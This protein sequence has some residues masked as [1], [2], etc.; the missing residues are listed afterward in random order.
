MLL[1][2][3][4][5]Y[6]EFFSS[7]KTPK[8]QI[9]SELQDQG[10]YGARVPMQGGQMPRGNE[11]NTWSYNAM[12][13]NALYHPGMWA[14]LFNLTQ[15]VVLQWVWF[16]CTSAFRLLLQADS[17][18]SLTIWEC[19]YSITQNLALSLSSSA[20]LTTPRQYTKGAFF[21]KICYFLWIMFL[22]LFVTC[23]VG[24]FGFLS[25]ATVFASSASLCASFLMNIFSPI[26][27]WF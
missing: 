2:E 13:C 16:Q 10:L 5:I 6:F 11:P 25:V 3:K 23:W 26:F 4:D 20:I 14:T 8:P 22:H 19:K 1:N 21:V 24:N 7:G 15:R 12:H 9:W 27:Q 17:I 18:Y